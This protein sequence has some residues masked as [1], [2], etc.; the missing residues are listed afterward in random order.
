MQPL[1]LKWRLGICVAILVVAII[2]VLSVTAY[3]QFRE[4]LKAGVDSA[5]LSQAEAVTVS[6]AA[7]DSLL[8][9]RKEIQAFFGP[10]N[11]T[12]SPIYRVWFEGE[13]D[14]YVASGLKESWPL[15]WDIQSAEAPAIG[16]HKFFEASRGQ[17][18]YRLLWTRD[19]DL[20]ASSSTKQSLN[21]IIAAYDGHV[22]SQIGDFLQVLLIMGV[23]VIIFSIG[24]TLLILKWGMKPVAG[25]T[26]KM[27]D[28]TGKNL[29]QLSSYVTDAP[30]ELRPFVRAWDE[31]IERLAL[32]MKQ[33]R[34]FT[35]DASHELRTPLAIVKSTLQTARSRKRS[36]ET[37]ESAMD[38]SLEDLG[39]LEHLIEQLL[40]LAHLDDIKSQS[41]WETVN[42]GNLVTD[43]CE[44]YLP[45]A[46]Q[47]KGTLKWQ[48]C[49]AK[50]NGSDAQ[51][52]R[53]L[54][55]LIDNA[56]KYGPKAR[57]VSV[58][59]HSSNGL[60]NISVHDKGGN[61]PTKEQKHIFDRFYSIRK[62]H[63]KASTGSGLGLALAQEIAQK[64][65][66]TI[67]VQS[68]PKTGTDF[69]VT[70]PHI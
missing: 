35:A 10:I 70:L 18:P 17:I 32:A 15:D 22:D 4:T 8:E 28:I 50:V 38:Q 43:V 57:E 3:V 12:K 66:G 52:R 34:R 20:R 14:D 37:Y 25:I 61:I 69:V 11:D 26:T 54:A 46:E 39:R 7:D 6:M 45:F 24:A 2:A 19:Q 63:S 58:S 36:S 60:V 67:T 29:N 42:L 13:Q 59:M 55:N 33:Q 16:N 21:I 23:A 1:S 40:T 65:R 53:L 48:V 9:A 31:M 56:I 49:P 47:Q 41:G 62:A 64:H 5:L 30:S 51:L 27:N 44:Q 68:N